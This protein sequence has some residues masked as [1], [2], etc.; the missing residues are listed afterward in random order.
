MVL[1]PDKGMDKT[2]VFGPGYPSDL[3]LLSLPSDTIPYQSN[4]G[5]DEVILQLSFF[6]AVRETC[7]CSV[8]VKG[9]LLEILA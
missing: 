2:T 3:S 4:K 5:P 1:I 9:H 8:L 7:P 6:A